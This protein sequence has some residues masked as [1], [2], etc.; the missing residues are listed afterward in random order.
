MC[1]SEIQI[2]AGLRSYRTWRFQWKADLWSGTMVSLES[3]IDPADPSPLKPSE[4]QLFW[5]RH[6]S[7]HGDQHQF[8]RNCWP[9]SL[10][11]E[12]IA[13]TPITSLLSLKTIANRPIASLLF[14]Q[15]IA[16]MPI[17]SLSCWNQSPIGQL[18]LSEPDKPAALRVRWR[19]DLLPPLRPPTA[20]GMGAKGIRWVWGSFKKGERKSIRLFSYWEEAAAEIWAWV[21]EVCVVDLIFELPLPCTKSCTRP[22]QRK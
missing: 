22:K 3:L 7:P 18:H 11:L 6:Y 19:T 16:N 21:H 15:T 13:N 1:T 17:A 2:A 14:L 12:T 8:G 4:V 10:F 9:F 5:Q 20:L